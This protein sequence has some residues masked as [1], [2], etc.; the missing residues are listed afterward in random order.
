M[1]NVFPNASI[2]GSVFHWTQAIWQKVEGLGLSTAYH[3]DD[4]TH[5][6]I[7]RLTALPFL[8][9]EHIAQMFEQLAALATSPVL[10]ALVNYINDTWINSAVWSPENWSI[11][12]K[13][14][15][16]NNDV[17]GWHQ[18]LNHNARRATLPLY[19]LIDL[20]Y[21]ESCLVSVQVRLLSDNK[22]KRQQ[23]R[24]YKNLQGRIFQYWDDFIAGEMTSKQFLHACAHVNGPC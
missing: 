8:P 13:S 2:Q 11:F 20:L 3:E 4:A 6:Y 21:Q 1:A 24:K 16:T 15:R 23:R 5:K 12:R 7:K 10:Q 9:H 18:R 17:E 22:L 14:V 19:L